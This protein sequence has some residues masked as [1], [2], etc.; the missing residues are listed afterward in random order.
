MFIYL[1]YL[2]LSKLT[3]AKKKNYLHMNFRMDIMLVI[4]KVKANEDLIY[5]LISW[6]TDFP[7]RVMSLE[8]QDYCDHK[9]RHIQRR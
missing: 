9:S 7:A 4:R 8:D 3:T 1:Y 6:M 2:I 5:W